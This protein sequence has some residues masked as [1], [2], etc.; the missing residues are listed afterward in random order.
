MISASGQLAAWVPR[1][2]SVATWFW[3]PSHLL[4][5]QLRVSGTRGS[6]VS[7]W[8]PQKFIARKTGVL[9]SN[10]LLS[11]PLSSGG[12]EGEEAGAGLDAWLGMTSIRSIWGALV[13]P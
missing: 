1:A 9:W 5:S 7:A 6:S 13:G 3:Q 10:G 8:L 4:P 2:A 12:G 11:P